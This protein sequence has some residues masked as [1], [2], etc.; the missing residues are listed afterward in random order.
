MFSLLARFAEFENDI[1]A[2]RRADGIAIAKSKGVIF[3]S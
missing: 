1:R 3:W 2:E